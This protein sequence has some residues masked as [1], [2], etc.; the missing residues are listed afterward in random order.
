MEFIQAFLFASKYILGRNGNLDIFYM[1]SALAL[2][3][4]LWKRHDKLRLILCITL[5]IAVVT[6]IM[7]LFYPEIDEI[8]CLVFA[9]KM[10]LNATLFVFVAYNC[11]KW[12]LGRFCVTISYIHGIETVIAL[13]FRNSSLWVTENLISVED[14][15]SRLRLFYTDPG[16]MAFASG[17]V[18][19]ILVYLLLKEEVVWR[20]VIG[21]CIALIDLFLSYG[22][23]GIACSA[24]AIVIML[25]MAC[26]Y[27]IRKGRTK[28]VKKVA[29]GAGIAMVL[30]A[31]LFALNS[32]YIG[33]FNAIIDGTDY[34]L[35]T[36]LFNPINNVIGVLQQTQFRGVGFGNGNTS[37][38]LEMMNATKAYPNSFIRIIA[39]GGFF[40]ILLVM[41]MIF[42]VG[43]YCFKYGN[44]MSRALFIYVTAYQMTGGYFTDPTN[45]FVYGWIIGES[46]YRKV[47]ITGTCGIKLF[48]PVQK[49]KLKIAMIGHKRIPSREGGVEIVVEELSKRMVKLGHS[50]DAYNRSGQH[51][52]GKEFN[53]VDYD[54]LKDYEGI[55]IIKIPTIQKKGIAAFVYS[56]IA[57]I[58]VIGQDYDVIHY[59]AEGPCLFMW[60][61][62]LFGFRTCAT[63]HGLDWARNGKWSS[64][65]STIIKTGE[66]AAVLFADEIIVLS[67]QVQRYFLETYNRETTLIPNGVNRPVKKEPEIIKAKYGIESMNYLLALSRLTRE[68]KTDLLIEAFKEV[69]TDKKLIIAGGSSDSGEYV[70]S[71]QNLAKD[72]PRIIFT[73]FVQGQEMEE[74]YSNA[75]IYCLPSE[76]EGMPLSLLEAMSYGNC[77]LVSDIPENADV[78]K[79]KGV[80][81]ETN[82]KDSLVEELKKLLEQPEVVEK[83]KADAAD[84]IC[85]KY[86]WDDVVEKTILKYRG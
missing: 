49:D 9:V 22:V 56:L 82:E 16:S 3:F 59:H 4:Y 77:C 30:V 51:V 74:L 11:R 86:S 39:E 68:K 42:G 32:T 64:F 14:S 71:L 79:S 69:N 33:R 5:P 52:S 85:K 63:V 84:Y 44:M 20:Y 45:F 70:Q 76:L 78:V 81:F 18:L 72:D 23:G 38:A 60:I 83:Y 54:N 46:L 37:V 57:S 12:K 26:S 47:K 27:N 50:V 13:L 61:P 41:I 65:A 2:C 73:G 40:G 43:Y 75:Y 21:I 55:K 58:Y 17:L 24:V 15:V 19:V 10:L 36:K 66:K 1:F 35:N 8:R 6:L 28:V 67:K 34:N 80:I 29:T 62:S 31:A 53:M 7:A 25:G 48:V